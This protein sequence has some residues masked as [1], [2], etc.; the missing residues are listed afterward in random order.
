MRSGEFIVGRTA[1]RLGFDIRDEYGSALAIR[2]ELGLRFE[3][4]FDF[5]LNDLL[6]LSCLLFF[7]GFLLGSLQIGLALQALFELG[8]ALQALTL[9]RF[10]LALSRFALGCLDSLRVAGSLYRLHLAFRLL[11]VLTSRHEPAWRILEIVVDFL[12]FGS[13]C[14]NCGK[15]GLCRSIGCCRNNRSGLFAGR[16]AGLLFRLLSE[17]LRQ[18]R[19]HRRTIALSARIDKVGCNRAVYTAL[20]RLPGHSGN[21]GLRRQEALFGT[22]FA[23]FGRRLETLGF[24]EDLG[25]FGDVA[26]FARGLLSMN[27]HAI[28]LGV[29][30]QIGFTHASAADAAGNFEQS[31]GAGGIVVGSF[32]VR[33]RTEQH[34]T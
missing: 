19:L 33:S 7:F 6:F 5:W 24:I 32:V 18:R 13:L 4:G 14:R 9:R 29:S 17:V 2:F 34:G 22:V 8:F 21:G 23:Y 15:L 11:R 20:D 26:A 31:R 1:Y 3:L 12:P 10:P 25:S 30:C 16:N 28:R 27:A